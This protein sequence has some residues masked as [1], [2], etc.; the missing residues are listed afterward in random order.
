M[1]D[2]ETGQELDST[3]D[4][5]DLSKKLF[6]QTMQTPTV[7]VDSELKVTEQ[8]LE[9]VLVT[10]TP[11]RVVLQT[12]SSEQDEI[13]SNA[14]D[15]DSDST[16]VGGSEASNIDME[17]FVTAPH[18]DITN[19]ASRS[20]AGHE[21]TDSVSQCS[22]MK[23]YFRN[24][25]YYGTRFSQEIYSPVDG[26]I[27]YITEGSGGGQDDWLLDYRRATGLEPPEDYRDMNIF[28][29]P[30]RSPSVWIRHFHLNPLISILK[31]VGTSDGRLMMMG[32]AS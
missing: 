3:E 24:V 22:S 19:I 20:A 29:R 23:H 21:F 15:D 6:E 4:D 17:M 13:S 7:M 11:E 30:N 10:S 25:D 5:A 18:V 8:R 14:V 2:L 32:L 31:A 28:I 1:Q 27:H 16:T 26:I 12:K 9:E